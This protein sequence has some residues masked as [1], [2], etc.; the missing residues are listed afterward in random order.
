MLNVVCINWHNYLGRGAEYVRKLHA[1]VARHLSVPFAFVELTEQQLG[2]D[3]KGWWVK[4]KLFEPRRF[5]GPVLYLDLD[6]VITANIDRLVATAA[7]D[8]TLLW[9]RDDFSYSLVHPKVGIGA[10]TRALL[11]GEGCCNSSVML[12]DARHIEW[13]WTAWQ[14]DKVRQMRELHGDQN[15]ITQL[16][17]PKHIGLLPSEMIQSYKYDVRDGHQRPAAVVVTHG[18]PK[19]H[20]LQV[21][22]INEHWQ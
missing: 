18:E 7:T 1:A 8:P 20:Q 5:T 6:V 9:M 16:A 11:G 21:P 3:L 17:W 10:D 14:Q 2:E 15:A 4:M 19:P 13:L 12:W 22:W